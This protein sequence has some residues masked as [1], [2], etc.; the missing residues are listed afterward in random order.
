MLQNGLLTIFK[1]QQLNIEK[2]FAYGVTNI[3]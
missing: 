3:Q 1:M 2:Y